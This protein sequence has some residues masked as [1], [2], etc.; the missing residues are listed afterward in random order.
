MR[1]IV[2]LKIL[3]VF[4]VVLLLIS[5]QGN[6]NTGST[7]NKV[8]GGAKI[9]E[10]GELDA[11]E[12][13][14]FVLPRYGWYYRMKIIGILKHG[15]I[16]KAG[17][18]I[19]Q[20]DG[21]DI[22]KGIIETEN[23]FETQK[24][25]L[26]KMMVDQNNRRQDF[27]SRIKSETAAFNLKKLELESSKF[28]SARARRISQLQFEQA[29]ITLAKVNKQMQYSKIISAC[30][31][32]IQQIRTRQLQNWLTDSRA[33]LQK[34]TIRSTLSGI[35]QVA[36]NEQNGQ[37]L[38]VGDDIYVG[39]NMGN[40]PDLTWMK[41]NTSVSEVDFQRIVLGQKVLVRLDALPK[42]SFK[43]EISYIGKLCYLK[44]N[45]SRKKVF[46]VVVKLLV[47]DPRLKP[48]MTVSCEYLEKK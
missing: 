13:R 3:L 20:L 9:I 26:A 4:S 37:P 29:K 14:S 21:T 5:C 48:G 18:S 36:N 8:L 45:K 32:K 35:F 24:A 38:K 41:V 10:A 42:V 33:I 2:K 39:S 12:S 43:G 31:L 23:N 16:V 34:L 1:K 6:L 17:D 25:T 7:T 44:D 47:S 28:E 30:D 15:S 11:I 27:E 46:E 22:K 40:V 19:V